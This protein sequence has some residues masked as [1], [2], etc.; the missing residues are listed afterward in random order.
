LSPSADAKLVSRDRLDRLKLKRKGHM[1]YL[2]AIVLLVIWIRCTNDNVSV[3]TELN[4]KWVEI[5]TK[6]DTLIFGRFADKESMI[7]AR[8]NEMRDG[9]LLPKY[10]SGPY[11]YKLESTDSISLHWT[12]SAS[13]VFN[14]YYFRQ[15]GD[16]LS[17][18]KFFESTTTG[19]M[20]TFQKID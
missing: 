7:L 5:N 14:N 4:G 12:L 17:I 6:S 16:K 2:S 10:G 9:T 3:Q 19:T 11:D 18:E 1:K 13:S 20:L 15:T 8:G